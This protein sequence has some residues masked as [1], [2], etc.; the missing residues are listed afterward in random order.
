MKKKLETN[1]VEQEQEQKSEQ[2]QKFGEGKI[3]KTDVAE[4]VDLFW[5]CADCY[6]IEKHLANSIMQMP[7]EE[8]KKYLEIYNEVRKVRAKLLARFTTNTKY[9]SWCCNK[10]MTGAVM[11]ITECAI[12][13]KYEGNEEGALELFELAE[14]MWK[15]FWLIQK[16]GEK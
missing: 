1:R 9:D 12:K 10:H 4:K 13:E 6:C 8:R 5:A 14:I 7:K 11:Q 16:L 15:L 2:E 3:S